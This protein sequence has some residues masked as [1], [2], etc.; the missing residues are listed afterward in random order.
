MTFFES[1]L[2][3]LFVLA[4]AFRPL[5]TLIRTSFEEIRSKFALLNLLNIMGA[6]IK[7]HLLIL[8]LIDM[9]LHL[10]VEESAY[11]YSSVLLYL[12]PSV[13]YQ[14]IQF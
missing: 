13:H 11:S 12:T 7:N 14:Y 4:E 5:W 6:T 3:N 2:I 9:S 8:P 1:W 10:I